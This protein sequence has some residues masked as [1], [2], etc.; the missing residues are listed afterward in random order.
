MPKPL[1]RDQIQ[2]RKDK[3]VRFVRDVLDDHERADEIEDES[4]ED[5]AARRRIDILDNPKGVH[6]M[7]T[8][9]ELM[10]QIRELEDENSELQ[11][12]LDAV[13]D[14][15]APADEGEEDEGEGD[16]QGEE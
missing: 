6:R 5:Y 12:Q 10:D 11:D 4:L 16:D 9:Q 14:I 13:A 15:V 1:T 2:A 8:K 7:P 3:A